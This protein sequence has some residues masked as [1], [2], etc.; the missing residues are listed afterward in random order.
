VLVDI[1]RKTGSENLKDILHRPGR[2]PHLRS[3][4]A[5]KMIFSGT[6]EVIREVGATTTILCQM[7]KKKTRTH[8]G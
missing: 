3:P 2:Y 1:P 6:R 7:L 5:S 4:P 8:P